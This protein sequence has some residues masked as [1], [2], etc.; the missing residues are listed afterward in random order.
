[1]T[2]NMHCKLPGILYIFHE[3]TKYIESDCHFVWNAVSEGLITP[4]DLTKFQLTDIFTKSVGRTQFD[5][6]SSKLSIKNL[7]APT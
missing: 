6:L 1:M 2:V 4:C 7:H 3:R 5:F